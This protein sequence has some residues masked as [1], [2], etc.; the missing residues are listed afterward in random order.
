MYSFVPS[1]YLDAGWAGEN[2]ANKNN[3]PISMSFNGG[4]VGLGFWVPF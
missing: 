2:W 4:Y 1:F 3:A